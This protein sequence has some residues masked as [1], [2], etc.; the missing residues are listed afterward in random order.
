MNDT[1]STPAVPL[2]GE[3]DL[4]GVVIFDATFMGG[5]LAQALFQISIPPLL[6]D[7]VQALRERCA[8]YRPAGIVLEFDAAGADPLELIRAIRA[9]CPEC[10]L[11][12]LSRHASTVRAMAAIRCGADDF[13]VKPV[14]P[15]LVIDALG[16]RLCQERLAMLSPELRSLS[17]EQVK[18]VFIEDMLIETGS[19]SAAARNLGLDRR[20]LRRM[21]Q[22]VAGGAAS[23]AAGGPQACLQ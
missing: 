8:G 5:R 2:S 17:I 22:R 21:V 23:E 9:A 3:A 19:M 1:A 10:R 6:V 4:R 13:I 7:S 16:I 15:L 20:S 11:V 14:A 12:V 18:G